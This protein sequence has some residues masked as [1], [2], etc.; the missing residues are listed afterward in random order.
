MALE[1]SFGGTILGSK[2]CVAGPKNAR[3]T[4]NDASSANTIQMCAPP[5]MVKARSP[6]AKIPSAVRQTAMMPRR[7]N[8]SAT[9]PVTST[10]NR[11][12]RNCD[13]PI[14]PRSSGLRVMS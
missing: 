9:A 8:R 4:P 1:S 2:A 14:K 13:R 5:Q 7:E 12:G 3:A 6:L 11:A 10:S